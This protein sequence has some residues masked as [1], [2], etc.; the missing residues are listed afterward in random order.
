MGELRM[1]NKKAELTTMTVIFF[2]LNLVF[3][4]SM[5]VFV[6]K[7]DDNALVYEQAYSKQIALLI[8]NAEPGS[9]ILLDVKEL[10]DISNKKDSKEIFKVDNNENKVSVSLTGTGYSYQ[11]FTDSEVE[12]EL[13]QGTLKISVA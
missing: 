7:A 2:I 13:N 10:V 11:Y 6:Q 12:L 4:V 9:V 5:F 8:D 3:F 1:K